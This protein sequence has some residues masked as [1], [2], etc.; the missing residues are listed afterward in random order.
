MNFQLIQEVKLPKSTKFSLL[1][2]LLSS[3]CLSH[4][5]LYQNSP[6][7]LLLHYQVIKLLSLLWQVS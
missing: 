2:I 6:K 3:L 4:I 5:S 7:S 1:P